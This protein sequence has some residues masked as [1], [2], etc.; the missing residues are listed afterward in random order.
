MSYTLLDCWME[1]YPIGLLDGED[2]HYVKMTFFSRFII[3]FLTY[4]LI[5]ISQISISSIFM[6]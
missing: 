2:L 5:R 6:L 3:Y 1:I 4:K